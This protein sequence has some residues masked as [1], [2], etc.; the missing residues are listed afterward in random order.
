MQVSRERIYGAATAAYHHTTERIDAGSSPKD[1]AAV[2]R[3]LAHEIDAAFVAARRAGTPVAC[4]AGCDFCCHSRVSVFEH[5]AVGVL[6]HL[7]T[8]LAQT[9]FG[10]VALRILA[11][12][13]RIDGMTVAEHYAA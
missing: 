12:A 3:R 5:E 11:N 1:C 2:V 6:H 10:A 7:R 8:R 13:A 9:D 4:T